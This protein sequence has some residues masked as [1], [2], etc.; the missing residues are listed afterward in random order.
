MSERRRVVTADGAP[1][2]LGPYSHAV[3]HDGLLF[4][5]GQLPLDPATGE[6]LEGDLGEQTARCLENLSVV[7]AA[8]RAALTDAVRC[9]IYV[10]DTATFAEVN[11]AY[12][13]YFPDA[14]PARTLIGVAA[15]PLGAGVEI[16]AI[17]AL[18]A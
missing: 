3:A 13:A 2:A 18:P 7:C 17:V 11:E 8:A 16:D 5:S 6:L 4:C 1:A 12:A 10:T 9:A 15:L 14:P